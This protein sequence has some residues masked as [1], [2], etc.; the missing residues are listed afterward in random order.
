MR[1]DESARP[2]AATPR[3]AALVVLVAALGYF[4]DVFDLLLF[5]IVRVKSLRDIGVPEHALLDRGVLLMNLQMAGMLIGGLAWGALGDRRGRRSVLF[6]SILLYSFANLANGLVHDVWSYAVVRFLAG[7]GLAGELGAGITLVSEILGRRSR[8]YG[9]TVVATLGLCGAVTAGVLGDRL[10][11]RTAYFVGGG[12]GLALLFL[13]VGVHESGLFQVTRARAGA[14]AGRFTAVFASAA[15]ARRYLSLIA[16]GLPAWFCVGILVAFAPE[17]GRT[18]GLPGTVSTGQAVMLFYIGSVVGDLASGLLSQLARSRKKVVA[19]FIIGTA[20]SIATY[21]AVG[22]RSLPM[23]QA[24]YVALGAFTGYWAVLI[25]MAS[26]QFG[27]NLRATV[28]TTVPNFVR[29]ALVPLTLIFQTL[30]DGLGTVPAAL[31]VGAGTIVLALLA[32]RGLPE[33]FDR[34]LDFVEE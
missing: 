33:T 34:D 8:G 17:F 20:A 30:R 18:L 25:T 7:V 29:G 3:G 9:T 4:V 26:E 16:I 31:W 1:E 6:G 14:V 5:A 2:P 11:W 19:V 12:M 13:R 24:T 27:T 10:P 23:F 32:L 15:R 21:F 28:T 22:A